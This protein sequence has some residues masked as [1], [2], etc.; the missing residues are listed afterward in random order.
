MMCASLRDSRAPKE[1]TQKE[2]FNNTVG[3]WTTRPMGFAFVF[4]QEGS[5]NHLSHQKVL[6]MAYF[7]CPITDAGEK[8]DTGALLALFCSFAASFDHSLTRL[9]F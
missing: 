1:T 6:E 8:P 3:F 9:G 7:S 2:G 4:F 5:L